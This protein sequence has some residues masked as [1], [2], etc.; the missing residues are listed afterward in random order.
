[1]EAAIVDHAPHRLTSLST[2]DPRVFDIRLAGP[3]ALLVAKLHKISERSRERTAKRLKDKDALDVLRILRAVPSEVLTETLD[4]LRHDD[5]AGTVTREALDYLRTLFGSR[6]GL[7]TEMAMRAT[8]RLEDPVTIAVSCEAL[9][10]DLLQ[11]FAGI[12][13]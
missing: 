3:A 10:T 2:D 12:D 4:R 13:R 8:E 11:E 1:M 5:L 6:T 7:G 9:A